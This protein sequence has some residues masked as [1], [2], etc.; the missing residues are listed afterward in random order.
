MVSDCPV[1]HSQHI[2]KLIHIAWALR[3]LDENF[4]ASFAAS[5]ASQYVPENPPELLVIWQPI[6]GVR[7]RF[8]N[9]SH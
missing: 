1:I 7:S 9:G 8:I 3:E 2:R 5:G 4:R 6:G